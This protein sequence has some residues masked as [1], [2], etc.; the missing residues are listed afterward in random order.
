MK[1]VI[2]WFVVAVS[3]YV[4]WLFLPSN[5]IYLYVDKVYNAALNMQKVIQFLQDKRAAQIDASIDLNKTGLIGEEFTELTTTTGDLQAKRTSTNPDMAAL[6][7]HLLI[8]SGVK[9]DDCVAVGASGSF[10]G[11]I[12]ATLSACKAIG[13]RALVICSV[14]SSQWGAN[15]LDFNLLDLFKWLTEIGFEKPLL[16]SYGGSDNK[17]SDFSQE[18]KDKI[19]EKANSYSFDFYEGIT[20]EEDARKF[21]EIYLNNCHSRI[22]AF[23]NIGGGLV[24]VGDSMDFALQSGVVTDRTIFDDRSVS[25]LMNNNGIPVISLLNMRKLVTE[26][27]LSWDPIPL[28]KVSEKR[29]EN[30]LKRFTKLHSVSPTVQDNTR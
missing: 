1:K 20:F 27:G 4:F 26:Y 25:G 19:R 13:A 3:V 12:V 11:L 10:P 21:F 17:G 14:G 28:P 23:V 15:Q 18:L 2:I 8:E 6:I 9:K 30:L 7:C 24:N 16:F 29:Y 5:R 22:A